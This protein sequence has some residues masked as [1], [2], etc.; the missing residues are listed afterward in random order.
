MKKLLWGIKSEI[1]SLGKHPNIIIGADVLLWPNHTRALLLTIK[2]LMIS[3]Y[4]HDNSNIPV[5]YISY[6]VRANTTTTLL[7]KSADELG[8]KID[9]IPL[10]FLPVPE[11]SCL[12]TLEKMI[13]KITL[14]NTDNIDESSDTIEEETV[15][16]LGFASAPC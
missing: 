1:Q 14:L 11:P 13:L 16:E 8:L 10:D 2:W 9:T 6:I 12:Q 3:S 5:S 7:F 15:K 4:L